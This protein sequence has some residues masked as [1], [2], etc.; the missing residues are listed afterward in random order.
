MDNLILINFLNRSFNEI[1]YC[2][3]HKLISVSELQS[4]D[5]V[6]FLGIPLLSIYECLIR[7]RSNGHKLMLASGHEITLEQIPNKY[8]NIFSHLFK[9]LSLIRNLNL[10]SNEHLSFKQFVISNL[11][12]LVTI[13]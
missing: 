11:K 1:E 10:T 2:L 4:A 5:T 6:I 13:I 8:Q 12:E 3:S 7:S 9:S